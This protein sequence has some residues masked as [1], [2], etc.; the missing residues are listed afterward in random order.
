[1]NQQPA[2][3]AANAVSQVHQFGS[4][5]ESVFRRVYHA[6]KGRDDFAD[7]WRQ[8]QERLD[9]Q[10]ER[11]AALQ[12]QRRELQRALG[13]KADEI[14]RLRELLAS[15]S[16][17]IILQ[18]LNGKVTLMNAAA[19]AMLGGKKNFWNSELGRLFERFR[20]TR[21]TGADFMPLGES[22]EIKLDQ[23]VVRAQLAA[24]GDA[25]RRIGT[26]ILLRDVTYDALAQRLKDG[27]VSAIA[28]D[29]EP[30]L[31]VMK[32][33]G[34]LLGGADDAALNR[35][36]LEK[37]LRSAAQ[38]DQL[39][40]ELLD[41]AAI[42]AGSFDVKREPVSVE[43]LLWSVAAGMEA[44]LRAAGVEL[45]LMTRG[46]ESVHIQGDA[47]RLTWALAHL[48]RNGAQY[49]KPGGYVALSAK[50]SQIAGQKQIR[51]RV[52]DNGS[53]ISPQELPQIFERFFRG[54][55]AVSAGGG[56]G[57]G[58]TVAKAICEAH[59]GTLEAQSRQHNGSAF[60]MTLPMHNRAPG[61]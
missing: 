59:R 33:A 14:R 8:Q 41:I 20:A 23:R 5:S 34:E 44:Q 27:F 45:L 50:T 37:L 32:L 57:Q 13:D 58:L 15:V 16:D 3:S 35:N 40:L 43:G 47:A 2:A 1:M 46:I 36:L 28:R 12:R 53:G 54:Q 26:V 7:A 29:M 48:L 51:L 19:G 39:G 17:G 21:A 18:D 38:I 24:L 25:G 10:A 42:E 9:A 6:L 55:N 60:T 49:N 52:T 31:A 22:A 56:L 61:S 30:P 11:N 4:A